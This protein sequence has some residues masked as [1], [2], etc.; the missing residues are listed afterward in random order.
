MAR[1]RSAIRRCRCH[2][3][4]SEIAYDVTYSLSRWPADSFDG[5]EAYSDIFWAEKYHRRF[6]GPQD[7]DKYELYGTHFDEANRN[8]AMRDFARLNVYIAD[9]NVL[10]TE[11][12]VD[13]TCTQL[14]ADIGGQLGLWIGVSVITLAEVLAFLGDVVRHLSRIFGPYSSGREFSRKSRC[15]DPVSRTDRCVACTNRACAVE[16]GNMDYRDYTVGRDSIKLEL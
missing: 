10:K 12:E 6:E 8:A 11:E 9:S 7:A 13:Y 15:Q 5:D 16:S 4:C 1:S 14:L 2:P 3:P